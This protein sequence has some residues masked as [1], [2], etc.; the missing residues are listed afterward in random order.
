MRRSKAVVDWLEGKE[1]SEERSV[2]HVGGTMDELAGVHIVRGACGECK[3]WG[4][5]GAHA[6]TVVCVDGTRVL[7]VA[8]MHG[9]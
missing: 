3:V 9:A 2:Q 8:G 5:D 6:V 7:T 1:I 4:M